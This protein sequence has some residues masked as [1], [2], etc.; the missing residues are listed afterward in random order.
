[1]KTIIRILSLVIVAAGFAGCYK[2]I[3]GE[4]VVPS[5]IKIV[6]LDAA[7]PSHG[8]ADIIITAHIK[9]G[10]Y[11]L[12]PRTEDMPYTFILSVDGQEFK[13]DAKGVEEEESRMSTEKGKGI[14]YVLKKRL[15]FKPGSHV[16][17]LRTEEGVSAKVN[18]EFPEGKTRDLNFE[19]VYGRGRA[20]FARTF[21]QGGLLRYKVYLDG[22]EIKE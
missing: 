5:E 14:H 2:R 15:R 17:V 11:L 3:P 10:S 7:E 18:A 1:M 20:G 12:S 19:P 9:K 8:E 22:N 13:D 4:T 21:L 6:D 16:I